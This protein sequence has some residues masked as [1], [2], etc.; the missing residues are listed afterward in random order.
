MLSPSWGLSTRRFAPAVWSCRF[1]AVAKVNTCSAILQCGEIYMPIVTHCHFVFLCQDGSIV[2]CPLLTKPLQI[3]QSNA[4]A[5]PRPKV[6]DLSQTIPVG[7]VAPTVS[8]YGEKQPVCTTNP[9][10]HQDE[11]DGQY[12]CSLQ[13]WCVFICTFCPRTCLSKQASPSAVY[14]EKM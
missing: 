3:A 1:S 11:A 13:A 14:G 10:C 12:I 4:A 5:W 6:P 7:S 8:Y 9:I 2:H